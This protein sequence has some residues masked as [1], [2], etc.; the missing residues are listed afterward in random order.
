MSQS[1]IKHLKF[2]LVSERN[3]D[4]G[5]FSNYTL[6]LALIISNPFWKVTGFKLQYVWGFVIP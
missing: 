4:I 1:E 5:N 3:G 2:I 6:V